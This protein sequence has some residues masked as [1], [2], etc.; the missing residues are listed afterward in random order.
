MNAKFIAAQRFAVHYVKNPWICLICL[1]ILSIISIGDYLVSG[2]ARRTI[3]FYSLEDGSPFVEERF[4]LRTS[5]EDT[6]IRAFIEEIMLGPSEWAAAPLLDRTAALDSLFLREGTVFIGLSGGAALPQAGLKTG[7][8]LHSLQSIE[9]DVKRNF[10]SIT[11]VRFF[12]GG[13]EIGA[14]G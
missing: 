7:G 9:Q 5:S 13:R 8:V 14:N 2:L 4:I 11:S 12:I 3:V 6:D 1:A 10:P